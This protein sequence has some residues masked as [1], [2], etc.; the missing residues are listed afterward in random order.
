M[1]LCRCCTPRKH[2]P[3]PKTPL[4]TLCSLVWSG[5]SAGRLRPAGRTGGGSLTLACVLRKEGNS[6]TSII[7]I[8]NVALT[9]FMPTVNSGSIT[10]IAVTPPLLWLA[11]PLSPWLPPHYHSYHHPTTAVTTITLVTITS[12]LWLP[13]PHHHGYHLITMITIT[14]PLLSPP[15]LW[16]HYPFTMVTSSPWLPSSHHCCHPPSPWLP[17]PSQHGYHHPLLLSPHPSW[18]PPHSYSSHRHPWVGLC[19]SGAPDLLSSTLG[20][21]S[22]PS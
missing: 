1:G 2:S 18:F 21:G 22:W 16:Y 15:S 20:L 4:D 12:S 5:P 13:S 9:T 3:K 10:V 14:P 7:K 6:V 11:L 19:P 8:I 17:P